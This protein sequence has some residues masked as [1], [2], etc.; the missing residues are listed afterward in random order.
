MRVDDPFPSTYQRSPK[1]NSTSPG[2]QKVGSL[3]RKVVDDKFDHEQ[4]STSRIKRR[5]SDMSVASR[6][7]CNSDESDTNSNYKVT[8]EYKLVMKN[9]RYRNGTESPE[10]KRKSSEHRHSSSA[11]YYKAEEGD[12]DWLEDDMVSVNK[13]RKTNYAD[14]NS[15]TN[16]SGTSLIIYFAMFITILTY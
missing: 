2:N 10:K 1:K 9:L 11:A 12:D 5:S 16:T 7:D 3:R 4:P 8:D 14:A 6:A 13:K 15:I